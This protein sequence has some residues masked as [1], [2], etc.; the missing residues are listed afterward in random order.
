VTHN[1]GDFKNITVSGVAFYDKNGNGVKDAG[2]PGLGGWLIRIVDANNNRVLTA[3]TASDGTYSIAGVGPGYQTLT[4]APRV[5]FTQT[6]KNPATFQAMSGMNVSGASFGDVKIGQGG[7]KSVPFWTS[8]SGQAD[9]NSADLAGLHLV[10]D[11]GSA[12]VPGSFSDFK[13]WVLNSGLSGNDAYQLS[14]Q[15]ALAQL[16]VAN[17]FIDPTESVFLGA[18]PEAAHLGSLVNSNGYAN[19]QALLTNAN[20]FLGNAANDHTVASSPARTYE[21]ALKLVL[22]AIN[23]NFMITVLPPGP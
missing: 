8:A 14:V 6:S 1:F 7:G 10:Q 2:E 22:S 5:G 20:N 13:K 4:E 19:I 12:F 18:I 17:H 3:T 9:Y 16:N 23:G 21:E 15:L 11:N